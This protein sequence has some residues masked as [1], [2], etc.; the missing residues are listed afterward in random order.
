MLQILVK[1]LLVGLTSPEISSVKSKVTQLNT[2]SR[3]RWQFLRCVSCQKQCQ[4]HFAAKEQFLSAASPEVEFAGLMIIII[5]QRRW[6]T[7]KQA[8]VYI[9]TQLFTHR[10]HYTYCDTY[11]RIKT[12]AKAFLAFLDAVPP[13]AQ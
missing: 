10:V 8:R 13:R 6:G 1:M 5:I 4:T 9:G 11:R 12:K 3:I 7:N 2:Q